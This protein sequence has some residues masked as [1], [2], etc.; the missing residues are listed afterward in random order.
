M[1]IIYAG[2]IF[3]AL[4]GCA[5]Q[6]GFIDSST[7]SGNPAAVTTLFATGPNY[8]G[9]VG[10]MLSFAN[11][12]GKTVKYM[13]FGLVPFN[14]VG[15]PVASSIDGE[16]LKVVKFTGPFKPGVSSDDFSVTFNGG[17]VGFSNVWYNQEISCL[18]IRMVRA[19]Y[20]DGTTKVVEGAGANLLAAPNVRKNCSSG[21]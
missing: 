12:S 5:S 14:R 8:A 17:A 3:S 2:L 16:S 18:E 13:E 7:K 10:V 11:T 20:T 4:T 6:S 1:R 15:D 21:V 19:T 9:G